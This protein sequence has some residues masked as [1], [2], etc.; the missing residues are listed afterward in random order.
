MSPLTGAS[1]PVLGFISSR[2]SFASPQDEPVRAS[3]LDRATEYAGYCDT[4][5]FARESTSNSTIAA[6]A[7]VSG[8]IDHRREGVS[9]RVD[10]TGWMCHHAASRSANTVSPK[11]TVENP[12]P[13]T[14]GGLS[15]HGTP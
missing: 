2:T 8:G 9:V 6:A 11:N 13:A 14:D 4:A 7:T 10:A 15:H 5:P 3:M 1:M 12:N